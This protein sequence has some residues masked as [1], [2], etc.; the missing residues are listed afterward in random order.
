MASLVVFLLLW[1]HAA[2][3]PHARASSSSLVSGAADGR[4][5]SVGRRRR[6]HC[7]ALLHDGT[8]CLN[9]P[10][11]GMLPRKGKKADDAEDG[12]DADDDEEEE[13]D[14]GEGADDEDG[15]K[16]GVLDADAADDE[17]G[18]DDGKIDSKDGDNDGDDDGDNDKEDDD[19]DDDNDDDD[20]DD[21]DDDDDDDDDDVALGKDRSKQKGRKPSTSSSPSLLESGVGTLANAATAAFKFTKG[22]VK[23]AVDLVAA[24]HVTL[25]QIV[26]KWKMEQEVQLSKGASY[27]CPATVEFTEDGQV[28]TTFEGKTF[29]SEFKFTERQWPRKCTIE[30]EAIAF[31]GPRDKEP[32]NM[33]YKGHFKRSILNPNIVLIR[34]KVYKLVGRLLWKQQKKCGKFKATQ[35]RYRY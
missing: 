21:N 13:D 2:A 3:S 16:T 6:S 31:Q 28:L 5:S 11:G 15:D 19:D 8:R 25:P 22:G 1:T 27:M 20:D 32:V 14:G 23:S 33:F 26:G 9:V 30:F 4:I 24:K 35:R 7:N 17:G 12:D 29:T 10:Y 34:G 18:N